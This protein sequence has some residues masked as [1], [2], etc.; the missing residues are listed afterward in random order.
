MA[1]PLRVVLPHGAAIHVRPIEPGDKELLVEALHRLS[2]VS[3]YFRFHRIVRDLSA[4]EL[5]YLT[6]LDHVNHTAWG[7]LLEVDGSLQPAGIARYVRLEDPTTAESAVTVLDD[8]Q[9]LGIGSFLLEVLARDARRNGIRRFV[10]NVLSENRAMI[11]VFGAMGAEVVVDGEEA[12]AILDLPLAH[13]WAPETAERVV[14]HFRG[15][16]AAT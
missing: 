4:D 6:E 5:A 14:A 9:G 13:E 8:Y 10:G 2:E 3:S 7:A 12:T 15:E 11:E 16:A 1:D